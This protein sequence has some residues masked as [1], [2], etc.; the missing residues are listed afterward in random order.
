MSAFGTEHTSTTASARPGPRRILHEG[1][2]RRLVVFAITILFIVPG[3]AWFLGGSESWGQA[4]WR[5]GFNAAV[6]SAAPLA[7]RIHAIFIL[8]MVAT[9]WGMLTLPKGDRRHR[10]LG[11]TWV[12]AMT[13]MGLTSMTVPHGNSWIAAYVGGGSALVLMA[14]GVYAVKRRRF[15]KHAQTM[16]MLMIALIVMTLLSVLPGRLMHDVLFAG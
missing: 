2:I 11:W 7:A 1:D 14:Y 9:G 12:G 8:T 16:A 13:L 15:R 5:L 4:S 6:F 3:C 10:V